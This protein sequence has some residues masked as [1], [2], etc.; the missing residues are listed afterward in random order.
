MKIILHHY[1]IFE[2]KLA[3]RMVRNFGNSPVV[4]LFQVFTISYIYIYMMICTCI[5][6]LLTIIYDKSMYDIY[7]IIQ[8]YSLKQYTYIYYLGG[9]CPYRERCV[10]L[11]DPRIMCKGA[12]IT[13]RRKNKEDV[14][15]DSFFWYVKHLCLY[16][17][18][19]ISTYVL[20]PL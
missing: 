4:P 12:K 20:R 6:K 16:T 17:S 3:W 2:Q 15:P 7:I 10:F 5:C 18:I 9:T 13:T 8:S 19:Y 11:H 14:I 1:D